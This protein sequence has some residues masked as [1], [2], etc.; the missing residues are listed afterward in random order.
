MIPSAEAN[1]KQLVAAADRAM[2]DA[3]TSGR[4]KVAWHSPPESFD[5]STTEKDNDRRLAERRV[6]DLDHAST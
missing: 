1:P 4:D 2:Y 3:K 5:V 6:P